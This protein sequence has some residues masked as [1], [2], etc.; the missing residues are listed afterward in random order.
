MRVFLLPVSTRR[1]LLYAHRLNDAAHQSS[2]WMDRIQLKAAATWAGWEQKE[3]GWQKTIVKYGNQALRKIPY[4]EWGLK[5]VP[6][7]ST[8]RADDELKGSDKVEVY[9]PKTLIQSSQVEDVL[10]R[11]STEREGLHRRRLLWCFIGMPISAPFALV[12]VVPNIPFFY[13]VYRAWS[14]W[15]ALSGGKHIQF[16]LK[17]RLLIHKPSPI[18]DE[19]Y[20]RQDPPLPST[21]DPTVDPGVPKNANPKMPQDAQPKGEMMLL[22]QSNGK[23][24]TQALGLP[25][26]EVELERAIWQVQ[27]AIHKQNAERDAAAKKKDDPKSQ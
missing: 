11:L 27:Q 5:S 22:D 2:G 10:Q 12:P 21:P 9:F 8:K 18:L 23:K 20:L 17:N 7:L 1:T 14:H 3:S 13:L 24:M 15:R 26:L 4:E 6:P 25:Q 19:V 16:L